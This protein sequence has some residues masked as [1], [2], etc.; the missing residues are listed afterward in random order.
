MRFRAKHLSTI[1]GPNRELTPLKSASKKNSWKTCRNYFSVLKVLNVRMY[2]TSVQRCDGFGASFQNVLFDILYT[3]HHKGTYVFT[4]RLSIE[5]NY[6]NKPNFAED[7]NDFMNL[8][9]EFK[10]PEDGDKSAICSHACGAT[11]HFVEANRD[12]LFKS[13]TMAKIKKCFFANKTSPFDNNRVHVAVHIRR[14]NLIDGIIEGRTDAPDSYFSNIIDTIRRE[15]E[16]KPISF[17]IY[18]QG[19]CERFIA[20]TSDDIELHLDESIQDTFTGLVH[21]DIL[22]TSAS[23][24][25]YTAALLTRGVVYYK[26]FWHPPLDAWIVC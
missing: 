9:N 16:T 10:F 21:A 17:H 23:S 7:L 8:Q 15:N 14:P 13:E 6:H 25:S 26:P 12:T 1:R 22:V 2:Y 5:H 11:Y 19:A 18:S 3:E 24:F 4:P 20:F